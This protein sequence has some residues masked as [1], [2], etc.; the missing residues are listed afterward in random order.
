MISCISHPCKLKGK[1]C[2][3]VNVIF[4]LVPSLSDL[5]GRP[6]GLWLFLT[7]APLLRHLRL[8][9]LEKPSG[10]EGGKGC[11]CSA[12]VPR[13]L[14]QCLLVHFWNPIPLLMGEGGVGVGDKEPA[15]GMLRLSCLVPN[16]PCYGFVNL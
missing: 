15:E 7:L 3:H 1:E 16:F 2:L 8:A 9:A 5:K 12:K 10:P 14:S 13:V 4:I 11:V 6:R